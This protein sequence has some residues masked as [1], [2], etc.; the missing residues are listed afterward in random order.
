MAS[1]TELLQND[2]QAELLDLIYRIS[3][4]RDIDYCIYRIDW[5]T[6]IIVRIG[7][8]ME[9]I[10]Q[11][12]LE[13]RQVMGTI[14]NG[15]T[16]GIS[17]GK[18]SIMS[19]GDRGRPKLLITKDWLEYFV[20]KGFSATDISKMLRVCSKTIYR[21]LKEFGIPIRSSYANLTD[22]ELDSI[23]HDIHQAFPNSGYKSMRGHL[24]SRGHKVQESRIRLAMRR[25][26]PQGNSVLDTSNHSFYAS[27]PENAF[28]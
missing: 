22:I 13:A 10:I 17:D 20:D 2:I 5:I 1:I 27:L 11:N 8:H 14:L 21:R 26:D 28:L 3:A 23:I 19:T 6:S 15:N 16:S 4:N 12:L 18:L 9:E 7:G 24:L 25:V